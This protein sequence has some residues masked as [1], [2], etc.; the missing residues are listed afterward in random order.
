[1]SSHTSSNARNPS[2]CA[3]NYPW[4]YFVWEDEPSNYIRHVYYRRG[5]IYGMGFSSII[6][7]SDDNCYGGDITPIVGGNGVVIWSRNDNL[8]G[9]L[10][11]MRH[12]DHY[13]GL[14]NI[15][16]I[17]NG[18]KPGLQSSSNGYH[19]VSE[20]NGQIYYTNFTTEGTWC[21]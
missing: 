16:P 18:I 6:Q 4:L 19:L 5:D 15:Y 17:G 3:D 14:R 21:S 2:I 9:D 7:V 20:E 12:V 13:Q 1:I 8:F 11:W 10:L